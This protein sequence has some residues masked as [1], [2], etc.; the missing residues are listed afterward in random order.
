MAR[1]NVSSGREDDLLRIACFI[2]FNAIM[3]HVV[4]SNNDKRVVPLPSAAPKEGLKRFLLKQ[5]QTIL[6]INFEHIFHLALEIL[7]QFPDAPQTEEI[8]ESLAGT[9][10]RSVSSGI[11]LRH[12]FAGRSYHN[13]LLRTTGHYYAT[14]YT[15]VPAAAL[16]STLMFSTPNAKW[17]FDDLR[18][19]SSFRVLDPAC[20]SGTL[21]SAA[22]TSIKD[23]YLKAASNPNLDRF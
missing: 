2:I 14:Y 10:R 16:L 18:K 7:E 3:F 8:L 9:A 21:V 11:V 19:L 20:G 5:W 17:S 15:S 13:L 23:A 6:T 12:D 4:L 22:Y 1:K